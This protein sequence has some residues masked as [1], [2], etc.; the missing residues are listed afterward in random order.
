MAT[1]L[2]CGWPSDTS[3][4]LTC[5]VDPHP[6][7]ETIKDNKEH[8]RVLLYHYYRSGGGGGGVLLIS[9]KEDTM[10][11]IGTRTFCEPVESVQKILGGDLDERGAPTCSCPFS[12]LHF[13]KVATIILIMQILEQGRLKIWI[14]KELPPQSPTTQK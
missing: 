5:K 10:T 1:C 12:V 13:Q 11:A 7:T 3:S 2:G 4:P 8:I 9:N 14:K 6:V